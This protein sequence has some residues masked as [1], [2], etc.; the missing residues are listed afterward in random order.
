VGG[1]II[2]STKPVN[3][4]FPEMGSPPNEVMEKLKIQD[5]ISMEDIGRIPSGRK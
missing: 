1:L 5:F 2:D 3:R 4:P